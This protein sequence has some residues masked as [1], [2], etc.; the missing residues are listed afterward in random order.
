MVL[1]KVSIG[2][3]INS[4]SSVVCISK[5]GI[6]IYWLIMYVVMNVVFSAMK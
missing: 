5:N 1:T 2:M 4:F 6:D 3:Y